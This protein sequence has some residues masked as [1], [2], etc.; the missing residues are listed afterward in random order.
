LFG[1]NSFIDCGLKDGTRGIAVAFVGGKSTNVKFLGN[2][3]VDL[4]GRATEAITIFSGAS[5][6][7]ASL[8]VGDNRVSG[9]LAR[10]GTALF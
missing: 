7:K 1:N 8:V 9:G 3:F 6:D 2:E 10:G 5:V 4:T